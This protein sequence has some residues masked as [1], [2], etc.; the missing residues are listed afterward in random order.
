MLLAFACFSGE[1]NVT[2]TNQISSLSLLWIATRNWESSTN[3]EGGHKRWRLAI[4]PPSL[5]NLYPR[6]IHLC[7]ACEV[8]TVHFCSSDLLAKL[9]ISSID[10][11]TSESLWVYLCDFETH[12]HSVN[13][14]TRTAFHTSDSR[15]RNCQGSEHFQ[16]GSTHSVSVYFWR[17]RWC[18][19]T[20]CPR[21]AWG[22]L[23]TLPSPPPL[24]R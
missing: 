23:P 3:V 8:Y 24:S 19:H 4:K 17:H 6:N 7:T 16:H 12:V 18:T 13:S 11:N 9:Y 15:T 1:I 20:G 14:S 21:S 5:I 22:I 2:K 10:A